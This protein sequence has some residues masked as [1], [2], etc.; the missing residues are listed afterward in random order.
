M[1]AH[2]CRWLV[3]N[4]PFIGGNITDL[5]GITRETFASYADRAVRALMSEDA[6]VYSKVPGFELAYASPPE[7]RNLSYRV[8]RL[9]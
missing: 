8:W 9:R 3:I 7:M 5:G 1:R 2:R 4:R 6:N